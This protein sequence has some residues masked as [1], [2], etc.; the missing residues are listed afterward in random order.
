MPGNPAHRKGFLK[1]VSTQP[2]KILTFWNDPYKKLANQKWVSSK[3]IPQEDEP[4][5]RTQP[6]RSQQI[7]ALYIVSANYP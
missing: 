4:R 2:M 6:G 3:W 7:I 1:K 5:I